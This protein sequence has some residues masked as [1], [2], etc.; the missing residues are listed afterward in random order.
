MFAAVAFAAC[1][2]TSPRAL[3]APRPLP[4]PLPSSAVRCATD[5]LWRWVCS[6]G[7]GVNAQ[8]LSVGEDVE[9]RKVSGRGLGVFATRDIPKGTMVCRYWGA[10]RSREEHELQVE[11]S[12]SSGAYAFGLGSAFVVDAE[13]VENLAR[14]I[15]HSVRRQNCQAVPVD[16]PEPIRGLPLPSPFAIWL[17]AC[18]DIAA[19]SELLYDYGSAYWDSETPLLG[20]AVHA[21][22][23]KNSLA[24]KVHARVNPRRAVIDL[25]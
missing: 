7:G 19:G 16:V 2:V 15:N 25:F 13:P 22:L 18:E 23:P 17:E 12:A 4:P 6:R 8:G 3:P 20:R 21:A 10:L 9:L 24:Y 5:V 1:A 11:S 14:Y